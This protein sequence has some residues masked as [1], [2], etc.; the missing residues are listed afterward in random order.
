MTPDDRQRRSGADRSRLAVGRLAGLLLA[1]GAA[2]G[3]VAH[4]MLP[5]AHASPLPV[6][7]GLVALGIAAVCLLVP[8]QRLG[9]WWLHLLPPAATA[10]IAAAVAE[11]LQ[12]GLVL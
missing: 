1:A 3:S 11:H 10:L 4:A 8:W 5:A 2:M 9:G 6:A 7:P 12:N